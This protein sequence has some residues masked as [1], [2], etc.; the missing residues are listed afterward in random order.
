MITKPDISTIPDYFVYYTKLVP[1]NELIEALRQ[2][3]EQT[4][5][6]FSSIPVE[7]ENYA[8]APGKW[9][10][11]QVLSHLIDTERV[12]SYRALRFSRMD[13]T[14]LPGYDENLFAAHANTENLML[15]RL[16]EEF[17]CV[18][19]ATLSLFEA[20]NEPMLDFRGT[21]NNMACS[22]RAL[23]FMIAGHETHH[24]KVLRE[25]YF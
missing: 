19:K 16:I 4:V 13:N 14:E 23:G 12:F 1:E 3:S 7:K 9:T 24:G 15:E 2:S 20:M 17:R 11:K 6:L 8:Y 5:E 10:V 22:A 18:R 25:R 21:A